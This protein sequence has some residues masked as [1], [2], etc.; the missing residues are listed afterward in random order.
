MA[1]YPFLENS[2]DLTSVALFISAGLQ[3][4]L[5]VSMIILVLEEAR[6]TQQWLWSRSQ[7]RKAERDALAIQA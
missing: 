1:G 2:E 6:Q 4:L 7:T 5:A 3:L